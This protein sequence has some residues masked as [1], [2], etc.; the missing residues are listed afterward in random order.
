MNEEMALSDPNKAIA[1]AVDPSVKEFRETPINPL[2]PKH[3]KIHKRIQAYLGQAVGTTCKQLHAG[4]IDYKVFVQLQMEAARKVV[5]QYGLTAV[6]PAWREFA[7]RVVQLPKR[8]IE[9]HPVFIQPA[10][11]AFTLY[12]AQPRVLYDALADRF[13]DEDLALKQKL[14]LEGDPDGQL[15]FHTNGTLVV[16]VAVPEQKEP[17]DERQEV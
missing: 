15:K 16:P 4:N 7:T 8:E 3:Y 17:A 2:S 9:G 6:L 12:F 1:R 11:D 10:A 14:E 13:S 5:R